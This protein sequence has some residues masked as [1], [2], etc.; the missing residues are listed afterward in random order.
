VGQQPELAFHQGGDRRDHARPSVAATIK[1]SAQ[2]ARGTC[3][4][5]WL[6]LRRRRGQMLKKRGDIISPLRCGLRL[7]LIVV[8]S[9][10]AFWIDE[11][12]WSQLSQ[13]LDYVYV[14]DLL[15][16]PHLRLVLFHHMQHGVQFTLHVRL[17]FN[18]HQKVSYCQVVVQ[19]AVLQ[20]YCKPASMQPFGPETQSWLVRGAKKRTHLKPSRSNSIAGTRVDI[21]LLS[22]SK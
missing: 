7:V 13:S 15:L 16:L 4:A 21:S 9:A 11:L 22:S 18:E 17:C 5:R 12:P 6:A 20:E 19:R 1:E 2:P 10:P 14:T 3:D 8:P